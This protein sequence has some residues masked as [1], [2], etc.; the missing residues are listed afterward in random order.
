MKADK[1]TIVQKHNELRSR[2]AN[3][4][5]TLGQP[6]GT[7]QPR[8]SNMRQLAWNDQL[9]EIAQRYYV[10]DCLQLRACILKLLSMDR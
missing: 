1:D 4:K 10:L 8:A 6:E 2:I 7:G 9:A 3:G 5:E